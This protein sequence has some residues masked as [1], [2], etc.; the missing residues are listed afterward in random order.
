MGTP[1]PFLVRQLDDIDRVFQVG[2]NVVVQKETGQEKQWARMVGWNPQSVVMLDG[3]LQWAAERPATGQPRLV[4]RFFSLGYL[5][6]FRA[7]VV[8]VFQTLPLVVLEWPSYLEKV[9]LSSETRYPVNVSVRIRAQKWDG[10]YTD[11]QDG[12]L[13]DISLGGCQAKIKRTGKS[14]LAFGRDRLALLSFFP[15]NALEPLIVAAQ[16]RNTHLT[17]SEV[18]MGLRFE[19][20]QAET[21]DYLRAWLAPQ[22]RLEK[23][24]EFLLATAPRWSGSRLS[25]VLPAPPAPAPPPTAPP[26]SPDKG[27]APEARMEAGPVPA[28]EDSPRNPLGIVSR[29]QGRRTTGRRAVTAG[30]ATR[31]VERVDMKPSTLRLED[32]TLEKAAAIL[33]VQGLEGSIVATTQARQQ[34][35]AWVNKYG[36]FKARSLGTLILKECANIEGLILIG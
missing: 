9:P 23:D 24:K 27:Q 31:E 21:L 25:A 19:T 20:G 2:H 16:I 7:E 8:A 1:Q 30:C 32:I 14:A 28:A 22:L 34:V 18:V 13:V 3:P 10:T 11:P 33:G 4:A 26:T 6:G 5:Y 15:Y 12:L 35:L 36:E 29:R 17:K